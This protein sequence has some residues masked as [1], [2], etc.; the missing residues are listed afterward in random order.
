VRQRLPHIHIPLLEGDPDVQLDLQAVFDRCY[1]A[2]PY[3][4]RVDYKEDPPIPLEREDAIWAAA[5]L[6]E[7]GLRPS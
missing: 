2:G 1:D 4:R 3:S 7:N 5:L 6:Q